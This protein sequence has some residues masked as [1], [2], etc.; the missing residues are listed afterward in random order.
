MEG[1]L[2]TD[3]AETWHQRLRAAGIPA[4]LVFNI[5]ETRRLEQVEVRRMVRKV[6]GYAV[7]G[8]R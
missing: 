2:T 5:D 3:T 4:A 1:V 6:D 7:P 8:T